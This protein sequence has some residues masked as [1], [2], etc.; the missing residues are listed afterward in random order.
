MHKFS[1]KILNSKASADIYSVSYNARHSL[2]CLD[3]VIFR[4]ILKKQ[5][6][7]ERYGFLKF[8]HN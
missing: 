1:V 5:S 6:V 4:I 2:Y 7:L 3:D 8:R